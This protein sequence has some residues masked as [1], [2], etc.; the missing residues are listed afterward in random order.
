MVD[1][2]I[3]ILQEETDRLALHDRT[4]RQ[5]IARDEVTI[6]AITIGCDRADDKAI[7]IRIWLIATPCLKVFKSPLIIEMLFVGASRNLDKHLYHGSLDSVSARYTSNGASSTCARLSVVDGRAAL[8][9]STRALGFA[10]ANASVCGCSEKFS[11][12]STVCSAVE[13]VNA[14]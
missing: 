1:L 4:G 13:R 3:L 11:A 5:L 6:D 14:R 9:N 10:S 8:E 12:T 2:P 7:G